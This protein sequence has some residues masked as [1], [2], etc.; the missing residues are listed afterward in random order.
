MLSNSVGAICRYVWFN[1]PFIFPF[2]TT[3]NARPT[4][5]KKKCLNFFVNINSLCFIS[6]LH[7]CKTINNLKS[8]I[9][10][11]ITPCS[12]LEVNGRFGGTYCRQLQGQKISQARNQREV[13]ST[14]YLLHAAWLIL[15]HW[16]WRWHI[17]PKS[18][19]TFNGLCGVISQRIELFINTAVRVSKK[20]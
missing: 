12:P 16:R 11:N 6:F 5:G 15:R 10:R 3:G 13:S 7:R 17:P 18:R 9:Y 14:F 4:K 20:E 1:K 8:S 19:L 2:V